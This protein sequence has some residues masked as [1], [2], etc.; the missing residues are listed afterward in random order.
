V[1]WEPIHLGK[2][3]ERDAIRP[4]IGRVGLVYP[5][6]R[7]VFSGPQESA[8][9]IAA[10]AIALEEIRVGGTVIL[11]DFEMGQWDARDRL[12]EMGA[13]DDDLDRLHYVEPDTPATTAVIAG[14]LE[15]CPTLV[16]ID[17]AAGAYNLQGLDDNNRRDVEQF[18]GLYVR[19][20]WLREV[21]TI[22]LDHVVKNADNRRQYA[23]GSER[24]IG[25]TDVHLG[26]DTI[27]ALSRGGVG[28][29]K[30]TTHK[31]RQGHLKRGHVADLEVHSD[32]STHAI[33]WE[34]IPVSAAE[35]ADWKPT[36]LMEKVS[37]HLEQVKSDGL[38][39]EAIKAAG[40]GRNEYVIHAINHL[41][42]GG[43]VAEIVPGKKGTGIRVLNPYRERSFPSF[44]I[45]P[46]RSGDG[47]ADR[48]TVPPSLQGERERNEDVP[49]PPAPKTATHA[50]T[51]ARTDDD[52]LEALVERALR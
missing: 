30:I 10:Y 36:R 33:T 22:V 8:K 3:E 47:D 35:S 23:I 29:F 2:L 12:H 28:R 49:P 52:D 41:L 44:P 40:L 38:N 5:G 6:K 50:P 19:E 18:T 21:A 48:S 9:T 42:A 39:R 20:F 24:K 15:L 11:I 31:D 34:F 43:Y 25:G 4:T 51:A 27:D 32:P 37:L 13:T 7:H 45:V 46:D 17:A 14:L 16:T 1:S 26:F